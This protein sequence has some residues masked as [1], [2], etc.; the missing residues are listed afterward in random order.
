MGH[1]CVELLLSANGLSAIDHSAQSQLLLAP[2]GILEPILLYC[3]PECTRW[4]EAGKLF[5][6]GKPSYPPYLKWFL[7][8]LQPTVLYP[9]FVFKM[10]VGQVLP[11]SSGN[12]R[13]VQLRMVTT[14]VPQSPPMLHT[15][16]ACQDDDAD[17]KR[18][19]TICTGLVPHLKLPKRH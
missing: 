3:F 4:Q 5:P 9:G 2:A 16:V 12:S 6:F 17:P 19:S 1:I 11:T 13:L 15:S 14:K 7:F 10:W 18:A 8:Y